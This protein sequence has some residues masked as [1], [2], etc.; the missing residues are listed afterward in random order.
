MNYAGLIAAA[1][2]VHA[3][4]VQFRQFVIVMV[5]LDGAQK[6]EEQIRE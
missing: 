4:L 1:Q 3:G 5:L 6:L 2:C